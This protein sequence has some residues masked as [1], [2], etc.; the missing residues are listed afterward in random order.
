MERRLK[1]VNTYPGLNPRPFLLRGHPVYFVFQ[2]GKI[3]FTYQN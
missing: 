3:I 2:A 1:Q